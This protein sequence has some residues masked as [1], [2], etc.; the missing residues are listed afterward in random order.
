MIKPIILSAVLV[1]T[2]G[3]LQAK[4]YNQQFATYGLGDSSCQQY[5]DARAGSPETENLYR[6]WLA[7][8]ATAFN[9]IVPDTFDIFG[10][11]DFNGMIDWIDNYCKKFPHSNMTNTVARFTEV[12][13]PYRVTFKPEVKVETKETK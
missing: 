10:S 11:T 5:L 4:D 2:T 3:L 6:S 12:V 8:Y 9:L 13:Y 1:F 7:G